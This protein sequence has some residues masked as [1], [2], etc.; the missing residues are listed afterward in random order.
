MYSRYTPQRFVFNDKAEC[1]PILLGNTST[2][3]FESPINSHNKGLLWW[4]VEELLLCHG[5]WWQLSVIF[6]PVILDAVAEGRLGCNSIAHSH[7]R[8]TCWYRSV[9]RPNACDVMGSCSDLEQLKEHNYVSRPTFEAI[10]IVEDMNITVQ[11]DTRVGLFMGGIKLVRYISCLLHLTS[12]TFL[13]TSAAT[14]LGA[15]KI[16]HFPT[17]FWRQDLFSC[18]VCT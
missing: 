11:N 7:T 12:S 10:P 2:S 16:M 15:W 5:Y 6:V 1:T 8:L 18:S 4:L 9:W 13:N 3:M 17:K 14:L